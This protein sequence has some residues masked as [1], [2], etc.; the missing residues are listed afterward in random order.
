MSDPAAPASPPF[1]VR[2]VL[3]I[4][5]GAF[6]DFI[7][8]LAAMRAIRDTHPAAEITLLTTP[9]F[10]GMARASGLF[11]MVRKDGRPKGL[12]AQVR[13]ALDLRRHRF[14]RVYDLQR[15]DRS[16]L[17]FHVLRPG[18]PALEWSGIFK[19]ASHFIP[20]P[21]EP[22]RHAAVRYADQL[23]VAGITVPEWPDISFLDG[24][25]SALP[26]PERF[27][28]LVPGGAPQRPAK[29]APAGTFA[30]VARHAAEAGLTPVLVGTDKEAEALEAVAE[31]VPQC[32][33]LQGRT[34]FGQ[35]AAL[36]RRA[37]G[38]V[39]NDTGPMHLIAV[40]GCPS[41]V[42]FSRESDPVECRPW[43]PAVTTLQ[44]DDLA[45]LPA[46]EVVAALDA[47]RR[48]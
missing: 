3:V 30:A 15:N 4:K 28:L 33:S 21:R 26:V 27:V 5:L 25:L 48:R 1:E 6:G 43:A 22:R 17:I 12:G 32:V 7:V 31:S 45:D 14:D 37:A 9:P 16:R 10:A 42:L 20:D 47:M 24:D 39:G 41:V 18:R 46:A 40:A 44:R 13:L 38:A 36:A 35:L 11:D 23:R 19:G 29:R 34:D 8:A 2:R